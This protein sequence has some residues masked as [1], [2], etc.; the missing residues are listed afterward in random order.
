MRK[1]LMPKKYPGRMT[2]TQWQRTPFRLKHRLVGL[3]I[4]NHFGFWRDCKHA[5]CRRARSCQDYECFWRRMAT[6]P[7][8]DDQLRVRDKLGP[9]RKLLWIGST[10]GSEGMR[11]Y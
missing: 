4:N 6:L 5:R 3:A 10:R 1:N 7:S 9:W 2:L 11:L 8:L